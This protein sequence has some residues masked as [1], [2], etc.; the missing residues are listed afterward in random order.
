MKN[1]WKDPRPKIT[2]INK[3]I[4]KVLTVQQQIILSLKKASLKG[5]KKIFKNTS[6]MQQKT[7]LY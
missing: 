5:V 2:K 1:T 3:S 6:K 4:K 7:L